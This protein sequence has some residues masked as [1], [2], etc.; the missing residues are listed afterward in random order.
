MKNTCILTITVL[1]LVMV[2][3]ASSPSAILPTPTVYTPPSAI[4]GETILE[5][6]I[7]DMV[8]QR[9][10]LVDQANFTTALP[11]CRILLIYLEKADGSAID[12]AKDGAGFS[13]IFIHGEDKSETLSTMGGF[14][15]DKFAIGFQIPKT[16]KTFKLVWHDNPP[17]MIIPEG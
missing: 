11:D 2:S 13:G 5:T 6:S 1:A 8:Y 12:L 4:S 3:C 14:V 15:E 9:A 16:V 7:G 17:L 10:A